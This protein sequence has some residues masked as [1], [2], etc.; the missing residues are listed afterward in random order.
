MAPNESNFKQKMQSANHNHHIFLDIRLFLG[1]SKLLQF[2][3]RQFCMFTT[4]IE[5][6]P[7]ADSAAIK[8]PTFPHSTAITQTMATDGVLFF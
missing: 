8:L 2:H 7:R 6:S 4:A 1:T 3:G 5:R